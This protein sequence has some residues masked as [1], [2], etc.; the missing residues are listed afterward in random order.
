MTTRKTAA[1]DSGASTLCES[2]G[3]LSQLFPDILN[4][5]FV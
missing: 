2:I 5:L 1:A 4:P 3:T